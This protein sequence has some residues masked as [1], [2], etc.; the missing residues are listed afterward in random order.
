MGQ[1]QVFLEP[2]NEFGST[3][4]TQNLETPPNFLVWKFCGKA[5]LLHRGHIQVI[6]L[7][8]LLLCFLLHFWKSKES[9]WCF[10]YDEI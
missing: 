6:D 3:C 8:Q 1:V 5:Q 10:Y 9:R 4:T 2:T 7:S